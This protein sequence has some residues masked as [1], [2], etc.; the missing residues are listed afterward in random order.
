MM[1]GMGHSQRVFLA[2]DD[3]DMRSVMRMA[4]ERGG[5]EVVE[6]RDGAE[7]ITLLKK[8]SCTATQPDVVVTD[9]RMPNFSGLGVLR[10]LRQAG[11]SLAI[12]L[13]TAAPDVAVRSDALQW[14]ASV[15]TKPFEMAELLTAITNA[16]ASS[17][18]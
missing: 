3:D 7:L 17:R 5:C 18:V 12:I 15:L 6:A 9:V 11:S 13:I 14:G 10:S 16:A 8:T 2:D 1:Q 4:L